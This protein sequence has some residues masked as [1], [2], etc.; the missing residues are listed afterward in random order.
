MC[1]TLEN[2]V[3]TGDIGVEVDLLSL[4][5]TAEHD[6]VE[7]EPEQ[8]AAFILRMEPA[9]VS[10][11]RTGSF[12]IA[13]ANN[14]EDLDLVVDGFQKFLLN[15]GLEFQEF[16]DINVVNLTFSGSIDKELDLEICTM[17]FGMENTEYEPEQS[18]FLV[19]RPPDFSCVLTIS[20]TGNVVLT[21]TSDQSEARSAFEAFK[22]DV[23]S[24]F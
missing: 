23:N 9:T 16:S 10:L 3:A 18:P 1:L 2:I 4:S 21:G 17:E 13:G 7:Y 22:S 11:Y 12:S 14:W 20:S 19:Y 6:N 15:A 8:Y 24:Y 5:Q